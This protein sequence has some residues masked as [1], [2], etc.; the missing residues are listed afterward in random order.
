N[1]F[2]VLYFTTKY[3]EHS[4]NRRLGFRPIAEAGLA[5]GRRL[6]ACRRPWR[7]LAL[8]RDDRD[9]PAGDSLGQI[10]EPAAL[11][12]ELRAQRLVQRRERE[13]DGV[14]LDGDTLGLGDDHAKERTVLFTY[15]G[16]Q[17]RFQIRTRG[18]RRFLGVPGGSRGFRGSA[19]RCFRGSRWPCRCW[20]RDGSGRRR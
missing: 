18:S 3:I 14:A 10:L 1:L 2:H 16:K 20:W 13:D 11:A 5:R 6:V 19:G 8:A 15:G 17:G 12:F 4:L 7:R 9:L